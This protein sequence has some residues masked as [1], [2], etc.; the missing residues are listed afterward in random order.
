MGPVFLLARHLLVGE[1]ER[2][3]YSFLFSVPLLAR[4][5]CSSGRGFAA[6][7]GCYGR[8]GAVSVSNPGVRPFDGDDR[9]SADR[10][11]SFFGTDDQRH[12]R[13]CADDPGVRP[14]DGDDHR[15]ADRGDSFFGTDDQRHDRQ[16]ADDP[17]VRPF[18]GDD[19][20]YNQRC[21]DPGDSFFG[22]DDQ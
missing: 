5:G 20:R 15:S 10:G 22:T 13:Q 8:A 3:P 21:A 14:F 6:A 11:D 9:R 1:H 2:A 18:D 17:G 7:R 12:D 19:H 16:C 4:D